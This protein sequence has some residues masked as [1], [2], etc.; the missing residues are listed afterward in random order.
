MPWSTQH[1]SGNNAARIS[2]RQVHGR[3]S[4]LVMEQ[5]FMDPLAVEFV[6]QGPGDRIYG[7]I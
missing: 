2:I 4:R 6:V 7:I 5:Q 3:D 1:T